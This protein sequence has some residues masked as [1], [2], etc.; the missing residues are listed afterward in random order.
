MNRLNDL[1]L[2]GPDVMAAPL[3]YAL[4][5]R[6]FG[7]LKTTLLHGCHVKQA[8][9]RTVKTLL[10]YGANPLQLSRETTGHSINP[11]LVVCQSNNL[12]LLQFLWNHDDGNLRPS[13]IK[14]F[15]ECVGHAMQ[16][17]SRDIFGV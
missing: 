17:S 10:Q 5:R 2:V 13:S 1:R 8:Q 3:L 12:L 7:H 9:L 14:Q 6:L 11:I 4:T 15:F 16:F